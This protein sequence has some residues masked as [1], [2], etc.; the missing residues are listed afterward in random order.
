MKLKNLKVN[1]ARAETGDWVGD[2]PGMDD[3][4]LKVRGFSNA[5]FGAITSREASKVSREQRE[6][7]RRDG[8]PLPHVREQIM[9]KA[10][11]DAILLDWDG[12]TDDEG[13]PIPY[14]KETAAQLLSDPDCRPF[15]D[16]V[17]LAAARVE[18]F[19]EDQVQ[20]VA[21]N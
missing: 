13:Q 17:S 18:E 4:R 1:S 10:M 14:T 15:R 21:G 20:A 5:D 3:L 11:T 19:S 6:G 9:V 16:A 12:L 2:L 8:A 7:G